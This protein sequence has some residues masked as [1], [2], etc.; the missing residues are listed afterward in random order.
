MKYAGK[1]QKLARVS[2]RKLKMIRIKKKFKKK[3][4]TDIFDLISLNQE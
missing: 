3:K 4:K 1:I 2:M